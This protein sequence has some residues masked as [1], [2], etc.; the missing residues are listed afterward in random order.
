VE[1]V[2]KGMRFS[3]EYAM[4]YDPKGF[5]SQRRIHVGRS[6]FVHW[7]VPDLSKE[8]NSLVCD[9]NWDSEDKAQASQGEQIEVTV[10]PLPSRTEAWSKRSM[11]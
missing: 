6:P 1:I 7:T 10:S 3:E 9:F 4:N 8:A 5:I 11:S 2:L